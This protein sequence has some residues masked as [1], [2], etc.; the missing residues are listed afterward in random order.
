MKRILALLLALVMVFALCACGSGTTETNPPASEPGT[1]PTTEPTEAPEAYTGLDWEVIDAMEYD[2]QSD[3]IYDAA[4]GDFYDTYMAGR[5]EVDDIGLRYALFAQAEA[6]LMEAAVMVPTT[7]RGGQYAMSHCATRTIPTVLWGS[8][9]SRYHQA[10]VANELIKSEDQD[11]MRAKWAELAGHDGKEYEEFVKQYLADHG[12]TINTTYAIGYSSDP[13]TW[14][15]LA[16]SRSADSEAIINT[17]DGLV[18]Y[19]VLNKM[20]PALAESWEVSD[21]G[22]VYTFHIRKGV[23]WVDYQGREIGAEVKADDWVAGLQHMCDT[24]GGLEYLLEG[25][26]V[27]YSE[28]INGDITD[29]SQVGVKAVDDYTLQYTLTGP[30]PY[31]ETMLTYSIFAPM[32]RTYYESQGGVF[33]QEAYKAATTGDSSSYTYGTDPSHIAYCGPY[34]VTNNTANTVIRF[35][36]NPTYWNKDNINIQLLT[37]TFNDGTD[38]TRI[39]EECKA[40]KV[41]GCSFSTNTLPLARQEKPE[42]EDATY[43]DLYSYVSATEA[44]SFMGFYNLNRQAFSNMADATVGVSTQTE[45]DAARTRSAMNNVHFRLAIS[46]G[47]DRASYNAA[48]VGEELKL[49]SLRNTYTPGN[50]VTLPNEATIEINGESKTYPAGTFYGEIMQDQ[51]DADGVKIKVWDPD[52]LSS[53]GFDGWYSPENAQEEL[54]KAVA[55]L[56]QIGVDISADHPIY[57][58]LPYPGSVQQ[59]ADRANAWKQSVEASLGGAVIINLVDV[60]DYDGWNGCGYDTENGSQ[61]NYDMYDD[62]G[63]GPDYGDPQTYLDTFLPQYSGYMAKCIGVY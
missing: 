38:P 48:G 46:M 25:I 12:Y 26:V 22:T 56:S 28:Y 24:M 49:N 34:L 15:V 54:A 60:I 10:I 6:K 19:D 41:V 43:Y 44:T 5:D 7:T 1:E 33:G 3:T 51:I 27:N 63:W 59:Y 36:A 55:E 16:T 40:G 47:F 58:D 35:E 18:E 57:L 14:D 61:A 23:Q 31:F 39:Y 4:L 45:E 29:F 50:F 17:F 11:A 37:W 20:Q 53:D 52:L 8:D 9:A 62:S 13:V 2:E 42:G 21:D 32:C 30:C